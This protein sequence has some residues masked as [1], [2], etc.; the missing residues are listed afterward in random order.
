[1]QIYC[2]HHF[3]KKFKNL[4]K[5]TYNKM[6][7]VSNTFKSKSHD[8]KQDESIFMLMASVSYEGGKQNKINGSFA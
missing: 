4:K 1:M 3:F 7:M 8:F 6:K 5:N 2:K